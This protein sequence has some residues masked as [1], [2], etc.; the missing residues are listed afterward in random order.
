MIKYVFKWNIIF[1]YFLIFYLFILYIFKFG[2]VKGS[3][4]FIYKYYIVTTYVFMEIN[5]IWSYLRR[6][7]DTLNCVLIKHILYLKYNYNS[8]RENLVINFILYLEK[9]K[10]L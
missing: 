6:D 5:T 9:S 7:Y 4:F 2:I 1:L 10:I 3:R 8:K